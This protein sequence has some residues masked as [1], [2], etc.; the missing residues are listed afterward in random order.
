[1]SFGFL[2]LFGAADVQAGE[3]QC[4]V[5]STNSAGC[6]EYFGTKHSCRF[7]EELNILRTEQAKTSSYTYPEFC[8]VTCAE[9]SGIP[10][11]CRAGRIGTAKPLAVADEVQKVTEEVLGTDA[12]ENTI[13]VNAYNG[14]QIAFTKFWGWL[15]IA[16]KGE[17]F[18]LE[19]AST[20]V[21]GV[22][23]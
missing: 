16:L 12:T 6:E 10:K 3:Y 19:P 15:K 17:N 21:A 2:F 11:H 4:N 20:A 5:S 14:A 8:S 22:R 23:G 1:M 9:E 18:E 7:P 13:L